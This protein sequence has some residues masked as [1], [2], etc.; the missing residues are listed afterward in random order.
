MRQKTFC[1]IPDACID[2]SQ[3]IS[4]QVR[5]LLTKSLELGLEPIA[6]PSHV[7][8]TVVDLSSEHIQAITPMAKSMKL[9][10]GRVVGGLLFAHYQRTRPTQLPLVETK[11]LRHGQVHCLEEAAPLLQEGKIVFCEAG[12]G[13]GKSRL[14]AHAA[15]LAL[16]LRDE[17]KLPSLRSLGPSC[18]LPDFLMDHAQKAHDVRNKRLAQAEPTQGCVLICAPSIE[19]IVHL[20]KEWQAVRPTLDPKR[21][22]SCA[23]V[24]GRGQFVSASKLAL[25][26]GELDEPSPGIEQWLADGMRKHHADVAK[27]LATAAPGVVG[28]M[29]DLEFLA[30]DSG[31]N[32]LDTALDEDSPD[33]EMKVY[34]Q[35]REGASQA[36]LVIT[37]TA[38]LAMDNMM[39]AS[40]DKSNLL[41][42]PVAL[43]V[44]E[45]H[46]LEGI[47]SSVAAKSLSFLRLQAEIRGADWNSLRKATP[48]AQVLSAIK[49]A[50]IALES[51]PDGTPLPIARSDDAT[52]V[53]AWHAAQPALGDLK[54][55]LAA[56]SG[57]QDKPSRSKKTP[58]Q[59]RALR[60]V[61]KAIVTLEK[62]QAGWKG[63]LSQ[64][65][66]RHQIGF[67]VGPSSVQ[68]YLLA[69]W[70]TTPMA[71]LLS[72][73][74]AHIGSSG[75]SVAA[76][77]AE[78]GVP[79]DRDAVTTPLHPSWLYSTPKVFTPSQEIFH[80]FVPPSGIDLDEDAMNLWLRR[81]AI[82]V[83]HAASSACGGTLVLM[84]SFD[85]LEGLVKALRD[86]HPSIADRL[87]VQMRHQRLSQSAD[88]FRKKGAA[89]E[90]PIWIAT[91]AAWT[92]LDL[93]DKTVPDERAHEDMLLTDLIIPNLP[94]GLDRGTTH[95]ARMNRIGFGA[96]VVGVQRRLRQG[97]GRLVRR[98]G[99]KNRR[100]W[101]LDGRLQHPAAQIYTGDLKR[102]L[103][104]Y[105]HQESFSV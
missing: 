76:I 87:V 89:G 98:E 55:A 17:K 83:A 74:L 44:D 99:V 42:Y 53:K 43:F 59:S 103:N 81:C 68:K 94:F 8:H 9:A 71:M 30:K 80:E 29:A 96:E 78:M 18:G 19:N 57:G 20:L 1:Y 12:T 7:H 66:R 86:K 41:P 105:L 63:N 75:A 58:E 91:G 49:S 47:Q 104:L 6:L 3:D 64:S 101:I 93:S 5:T 14:I 54:E 35:M 72:G 65:P 11:G 38:M 40:S 69:R 46:T 23:V 70:E 61:Q 13:S 21:L 52:A 95:M 33:E 62:I 51:V 10:P 31:L 82:A 26:L 28:L 39:L 50:A 15:R 45:A 37:S 102:V 67:M 90:K 27:V 85:R 92:G 24:L 100:I 4:A 97:L 73:T 48:A 56:L 60:Y 88:V 36:D 79:P 2:S 25:L 16:K 32:A 34:K 22:V 77:K 84:T